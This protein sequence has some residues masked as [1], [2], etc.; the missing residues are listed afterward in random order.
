MHLSICELQ[1]K[2]L[3]LSLFLLLKSCTSAITMSFSKDGLY[4]QGMDS[5]HVCLFD[6]TLAAS[7]FQSYEIDEVQDIK[8]V[9]IQTGIFC[10][11]L[12]MAKEEHVLHIHYEGDVDS[13]Q[14][15]CCSEKTSGVAEVSPLSFVIPLIDIEIQ[16]FDIPEIDYEIEFTVSS[17]KLHD[18]VS[19]LILFGS[20]MMVNTSG[21]E[22]LELSSKGIDGEMK[23]RLSLE[24]YSIVEG[25]E[26]TLSY[27]LH[28]LHKMCITTKLTPELNICMSRDTPMKV[29]YHLGANSIAAFYIAP[30]IED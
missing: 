24:E 2:Q 26:M 22:L 9:S 1:K 11:I 18:I 3:F 7:W 6:I 15:D 14:M 13:L 25:L 27:S 4:L 17:K 28:Y 21:F 30:K 8:E 12:S 10:S 29:F 5:S 23:V 19:Q 20:T 16:H